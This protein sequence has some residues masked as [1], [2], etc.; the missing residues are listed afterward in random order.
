MGGLPC[1]LEWPKT[2]VT[3]TTFSRGWPTSPCVVLTYR[4]ATCRVPQNSQRMRCCWTDVCE[5]V[6]QLPQRKL[7]GSTWLRRIAL[8]P[9][10]GPGGSAM[11]GGWSDGIS[12]DL[13]ST[14]KPLCE[15]P[16]GGGPPFRRPRRQ[17]GSFEEEVRDRRQRRVA[18]QSRWARAIARALAS[19]PYMSTNL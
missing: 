11:W 15:N 14:F 13:R 4:A 3:V 7:D 6:A 10:K 9:S 2:P 8:V 19:G 5:V 12:R 18:H 1:R 16:C 17:A